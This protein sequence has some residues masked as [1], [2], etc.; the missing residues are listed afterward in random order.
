MES[1]TIIENKNKLISLVQ[2]IV[3]EYNIMS[4]LKKIAIGGEMRPIHFGFSALSQWCDISGL[5]L[6]DLGTC[7]LRSGVSVKTD[8]I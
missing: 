8:K 3:N 2:D 5:S 1:S 6:N 4:E 7:I